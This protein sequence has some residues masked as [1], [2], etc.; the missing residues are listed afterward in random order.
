MIDPRTSLAMAMHANPGLYALL[1]GSGVSRSARIPTGWEVVVDMIRRVAAASG[2][3]CEPNP[4]EWYEAKYGAEPAYSDLLEAVGKNQ[5]ERSRLL[6]AYFEPASEDGSDGVRQP[7]KAHFA[8]ARMV[9]RGFVRVILT[10]NFDRL[11]KQ[12]LEG[13]G[14]SPTVISTPEAIKGAPP[15]VHCDCA[16][17]KLHGDYMDLRTRNTPVDLS[18]YDRRTDALLERVLDEYGLIICGWSAEWDEAL[19]KAIERRKN[20]RFT[21]WWASLGEPSDSGK[22][23]I[24]L[25]QAQIIP[26]GGA[27][28]FFEGLDE[29]LSA[30]DEFDRPHP[31]STKIA[32]TLTKKYLSETKYR[33]QLHDL[34]MRE[35][36][37]IAVEVVSEKYPVN[38]SFTENDCAKRILAFDVLSE[39]AT[40]VLATG[41]FWDKDGQYMDIWLRAIVRVANAR[42]D[43]SGSGWMLNLGRHPAR[44]LLYTAGIAFAARNDYAAVRTL[45]TGVRVREY[46]YN[47]DM[48]LAF[49]LA[50]DRDAFE[51]FKMLPDFDRRHIPV[52]DHVYDVLQAA[53]SEILPDKTEY[54]DA[55][56][57]F[58]VL[59]SFHSADMYKRAIPG[60]FMYRYTRTPKSSPL[61]QL[62][63]DVEDKKEQSAFLRAGFC[64]GNMTRF[65]EAADMFT[66]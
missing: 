11:M 47:E 41:C 27:D 56:D 1:L 63:A 53:F 5:A 33:I 3:D 21:T 44:L 51:P 6:R 19:R 24:N 20:R 12:A 60:A 43:W 40:H 30:L 65:R 55:F 59:Q 28:E 10:T 61:L 54:Q 62:L 49:A 52:S 48:E 45:L 38:G 22:R 4:E 15:L 13:Q 35:V 9:R 23:L 57:T 34:L 16:L 18:A 7:T 31:V 37:R 32:V 64:D 29:R 66:R 46:N 36:D 42:K 26:I 8:I 2:Q 39:T 14:V 58:E 50:G 25:I 17:V